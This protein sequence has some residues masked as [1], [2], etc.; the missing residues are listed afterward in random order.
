MVRMFRLSVIFTLMFSVVTHAANAEILVNPF[1][2]DYPTTKTAAP[3][4]PVGV[5]P[6]CAFGKDLK[7]QVGTIPVPF[8]SVGNILAADDIG[9]HRY[10][11]GSSPVAVNFLGLSGEKNGLLFTTQ[12]GFI[13]TAHVRDTA[14][15]T[16][17]LFRH[18]QQRLGTDYTMDLPA[19]LRLRRIQ[20]QAHTT[21]LTAEERIQFSADAAALLAFRLAQWHE[22]AQWFGMVSVSGF[23][24]LA[25]AFSSED[26]YSNMLGAKLANGI[27]LAQPDLTVA[28]FGRAM[29]NALDKQL[30]VL[31]VQP[32][33]V[34][35]AKIT[36]LD[37]VWWDSSKRLP[38][39]WTV[40]FRDYH[41]GLT[42]TPH[43]PGA[44][45]PLTLSAQS[46]NGEAIENWVRI[47]LHAAKEE[48][49]FADLPNALLQDAVWTVEQFQPLADFAQQQDRQA[50]ATMKAQR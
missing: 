40:L 30:T 31:G 41:F 49:A 6:C 44:T 14:D 36:A 5:R 37:G 7:A 9:Q 25:S 1:S 12:G 48:A 38:D 13:D 4:A 17:Y 47:E 15:Y 2:K 34:A 19:E 42:L 46:V 21:P 24:E 33:A 23:K 10:N 27:L 45:T 11:D 50:L 39:K 22:I 29:D 43:Y 26:L 28:E 20:W 35:D 18:M 8:V 16:Y 3:R 32:A